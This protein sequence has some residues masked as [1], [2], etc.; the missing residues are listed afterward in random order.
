MSWMKRAANL[1]QLL[2]HRQKVEA[3]LD[4]EVEAYFEILVDRHLEEGMS[5]E[6]AY[7]AVQVKFEG[8]ERVK[9]DVRNVRVGTMLEATLHDVCYAA[10][11]LR[12]RP[13]FVA[14][15]MCSLAIG[16][17]ANSAIY[18]F[19]DWW[20]LRPLPV[21]EPTRVVAVTPITNAMARVRTTMSYPNYVDLRDRNRTFDGLVAQ[22]FS[23]FGF[24]PD[25]TVLPRMKMGMFVSGNFFRVLGIEP[26]IGRDFRPE[27]DQVMGR[28]AVVVLSHDLWTSAYDAK[29]SIIGEKLRL[30]GI[31]LTII[32]V[33]PES[34]TGT[35]QFLRPALY[36]PLA[37]SARLTNANNLDQRQIPWL[38]VK[39][40]L[41][42][43][44]SIAQAQADLGAIA[45]VLRKTYP[46]TDANLRLKVESHL[47]FQTELSPPTTAMLMM[48][49][50]L[51]ACVLLVAC[52][53]VAG[54]LLSRSSERAREIAL[55]LAVG[56]GRSAIVRQL[57]IENLLLAAIGGTAGLAIAYAGVK[58]FRSLPPPSADVPFGIDIHLDSRAL[59]FTAS[60]SIASSFLFGLLPAFRTSRPDLVSALKTGDAVSSD[61]TRLLGR[62]LLVSGQVALSL[63]LLIVSAGLVGGF[64][65][66]LSQGPGFRTDH[67]LLMSFDTN[68]AHYTD[69]QGS[70]FY[71]QLLE[72]TRLSPNVKSAALASSIPLAI[73]ASME[74]VVPDG[75]QL[76][77]GQDSIDVFDNV[78]SE[79]YFQTIGIPIVQGRSFLET[80]KENTPAVAI[81]NEQFARHYW[82]KQSPLGKRLRL[83]DATG[84]PVE[85]VGVAKTTK[86]V[87]VS[88]APLDFV[89]LPSGQ[90]QRPQMT[91][92]SEPNS[93]EE[94]LLAPV[95]KRVV[96]TI[97][98]DMPVF[99]VRSMKDLYLDRAEKT[100]KLITDSVAWLGIMGLA[101]AVVG[102]YGLL[103]HSVAR[104][105]RE[106]GVRMALGADRQQVV[107]IVMR[108]G[109]KLGV[110]GVGV[111][112][113]IGSAAYKAISSSLFFNFGHLGVLPFAAVSF[114][115][116]ITMM[117]ATYIP[118]RRASH[119]DPMRA[120][121]DE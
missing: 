71:Q 105:I 106:I 58:L 4:A 52:A 19:A 18:S 35:D 76:K 73:G 98:R 94:T 86:Y 38:V 9:Q 121:R 89:Y 85:I 75:Y 51:A 119:I 21:L 37:M 65:A 120:L 29:P 72:K 110:A 39:G 17:G 62:K 101:L 45:A 96:Q 3:E 53:N 26:V 77:P 56:A 81:V 66:E 14:V 109:A 93:P 6:E 84:K 92:I 68:L 90:N 115:L 79:D 78:V 88:E 103:A 36:V 54:L 13:G 118:A 60:V 82:P 55:R 107:N 114:I 57:L 34:F 87:F 10:R 95:L 8:P 59:L 42:P 116:F 27:E 11:T 74:G 113:I 7:R 24:A 15:V 49:M 69:A 63:V 20:L 48:L 30:N 83:Q 40:R 1:Y 99:D 41:N 2:F 64:R 44:V 102:L 12:K 47:Q 46:H 25:Q 108:Q 117:I 22:A 80:D 16:I 50:F 112:L 23:A 5:R 100:P 61:K 111:G 43:G 33:T 32:G 28:D 104:R 31:E 91:L 97:D 67:L 70:H